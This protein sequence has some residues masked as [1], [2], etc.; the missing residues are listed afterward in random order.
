[1]IFQ[2]LFLILQV[3]QT[4]NHINIHFKNYTIMIVAPLNEFGTYINLHPLFSKV[5]Q[6]LIMLDFSKPGEKVFIDGEKLIAIPSFN[7]AKSKQEAYLEAHNRYI[8]IQIC[9]Q[10]TETFGWKNREEC[11]LPKAEF[12]INKDIIFYSDEPSTY[13]T[14]PENHFAIFFPNDCHAP[15]IGNG[16]IKKVVFKVEI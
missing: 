15:L 14:I 9:L 3:F 13:F 1:M 12:D 10:G 6:S 11:K 8:D 4:F 5:E 2:Q 16:L 7:K